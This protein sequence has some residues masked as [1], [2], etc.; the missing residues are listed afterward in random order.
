VVV[1][2][3]AEPESGVPLS[4]EAKPEAPGVAIARELDDAHADALVRRLDRVRRP[5]DVAVVSIHWG[6]NWGYAVDD[7]HVRFAHALVERGV[8]VVFGHSSHHPRPIELHRG[9]PIFYGCG[10]LLDDYEGISGYEPFKNDL[11]LLYL[12]SVDDRD[13][14]DVRMKPFRIRKMRLERATTGDAAWLA[15]SL[16]EW[17]RPYGTR[18]FT[19]ADGALGV[20]SLEGDE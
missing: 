14:I 20:Q 10:D 18:V 17:S 4:W 11:V 12:L 15:A 6:T 9:K 13:R 19:R 2:A 16:S 7:A 8:D 3:T 1:V 5:G